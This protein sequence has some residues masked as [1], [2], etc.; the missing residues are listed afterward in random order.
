MTKRNYVQPYVK[1]D[2]NRPADEGTSLHDD[3]N[4]FYREVMKLKA[5]ITRRKLPKNKQVVESILNNPRCN[6]LNDILLDLHARPKEDLWPGNQ[7][8]PPDF[9]GVLWDAVHTA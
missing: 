4:K 1:A 5:P 8:P 3:A 9:I 7:D 2:L 6:E